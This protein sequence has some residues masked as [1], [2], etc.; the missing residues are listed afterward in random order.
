MARKTVSASTQSLQS[1]SAINFSQATLLAISFWLYWDANA[2]DDKMAVESQSFGTGTG[3]DM[4]FSIN[5]NG[6]SGS[7]EIGIVGNA[8]LN[9]VVMTRPSAATYHHWLVNI[10]VSHASQEVRGVYI[11]SSSQILTPSNTNNNTVG[12]F[13][14]RLINVLARDNSSL[15]ADGR[16]A[17]LAFWTGINLS[18]TDATNLFNG[19]LPSSVQAGNLVNYWKLCGVA[20]PETPSA[21]AVNMTVNGAT[22][23]DHPSAV[24]GS[25]SGAITGMRPA[26]RVPNILVF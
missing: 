1:T 9:N 2:S 5:P 3:S 13:S 19:T 17:E 10:D 24:S 22:F 25:C 14:S 21:G 23:V 18:G 26:M 7:V 8:G 20:S 12:G 4:T 16:I 15:F 6:S 11:D